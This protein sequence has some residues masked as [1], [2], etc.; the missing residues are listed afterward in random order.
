MINLNIRTPFIKN[1]IFLPV[2]ISIFCSKQNLTQLGPDDEF[3]RAMEFYNQKKYDQA[4][5][6][7]E[8][9]IFY[10]ATTEFVDDAQFYLADSYLKKKDYAQAI[11]EFEYLIKNFPNTPFLERS[12]LLRAQAYFLK[13]PGYEK[14][15]TETKE[16]ISL[17]DE[18]LTR[19]PNSIYSDTAKALILK[20]RDRLAKKEVENGKLYL[21][22]KEYDSAILYFKYVID[23]Y[24]ETSSAEESKFL[25]AQTYE[26]ARR[27]QEAYDLYKDLV[28]SPKWKHIAEEKIKR[29]KIENP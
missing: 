24:P 27:M 14:D 19:F 21:K 23:N 28:D 17:L 7:F 10:Y 8:R 13:S 5:K 3:E 4:I 20:A 12:Y 11:T 29:L 16:A 18:F 22:M 9:I 1:L 2:I 15:Q 26:K 25:L 6:L